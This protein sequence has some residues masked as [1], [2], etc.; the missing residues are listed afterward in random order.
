MKIWARTPGPGRMNTSS[1]A[2]TLPVNFVSLL[3]TLLSLIP[4]AA[5]SPRD[6][7]HRVATVETQQGTLGTPS[8]NSLSLGDHHI[9]KDDVG[10]FIHDFPDPDDLGIVDDGKDTIY[11]DVLQFEDCLASFLENE[12]THNKNS[13]Q[14]LEIFPSLLGGDAVIWWNSE[15]TFDERRQLRRKGMAAVFHS[16]RDR[17]QLDR[18]MAQHWE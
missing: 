17:F 9:K 15:L 8:T 4:S 7:Q 2:M 14:I 10:K 1:C 3:R 13:R 18:A 5:R 12:E 6:P 16:I 11:T